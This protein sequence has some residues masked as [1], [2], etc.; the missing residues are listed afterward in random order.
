MQYEK[1]AL[2]VT[3][4]VQGRETKSSAFFLS[5]SPLPLL[6]PHT[7]DDVVVVGKFLGLQLGVDI[8]PVQTDLEGP[9][10]RGNEGQSR[11]IP[12]EFEEELFRQTDGFWLIPSSGA[13][14]D[15][16]S[17]DVTILRQSAGGGQ[18]ASERKE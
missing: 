17:H 15:L 4:R 11:N 16:Y 1:L 13:I 3:C 10:R 12:L 14:G 9:A 7:R 6:P 2:S 18:G 8:F 5:L